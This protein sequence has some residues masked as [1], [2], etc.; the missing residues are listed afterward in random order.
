MNVQFKKGVLELCVLSLL[1]EN[2]KYGYELAE[3]IGTKIHISEGSIYPLL[4][5]LQKEGYFD[6]YLKESQNGPAR[7]YYRLTGKGKKA[8]H[9]QYKEWHD[10]VQ[11]VDS[12]IGG[13]IYDKV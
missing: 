5:R 4:R 1:S 9:E 11:Q 3:A 10:F 6:V 12:L 7:K 2:D 8:Y 13:D